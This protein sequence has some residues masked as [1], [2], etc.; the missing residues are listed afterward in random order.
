MMEALVSLKLFEKVIFFH[1]RRRLTVKNQLNRSGDLIE[2]IIVDK[3]IA[4]T[5]L[6]IP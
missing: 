4:A 5:R 3:G 1:L 6:F 2:K